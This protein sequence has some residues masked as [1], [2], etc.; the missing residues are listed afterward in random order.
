LIAMRPPVIT[1][2][3]CLPSWLGMV[4]RWHS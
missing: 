2:T 4:S 1:G 3:I